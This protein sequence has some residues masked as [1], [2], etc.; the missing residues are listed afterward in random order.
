MN[1]NFLARI[2]FRALTCIVLLSACSQHAKDIELTDLNKHRTYQDSKLDENNVYHPD[3]VSEYQ[4]VLSENPKSPNAN[5]LL[6]RVLDDNQLGLLLKAIKLDSLFAPAYNSL[7]VYYLYK[8]EQP[9]KALKYSNKAISIDSTISYYYEN[10]AQAYIKLSNSTEDL[11]EKYNYSQC[12]YNMYQKANEK[13]PN[14]NYSDD[15]IVLENY[16]LELDE[17]KRETAHIGVWQYSNGFFSYTKN[18]YQNGTWNTNGMF[19]YS[20]GSW[21]R[22]AGKITFYEGGFIYST[23]TINAEGTILS[24]KTDAGTFKLKKRST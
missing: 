24:E 11:N 19:G 20:S 12:S 16:I 21:E 10:A 8:S 4:D 22:N 1:F 18:I 9:R 23:A 15:V 7:S 6:A 2:S 17:L 13:S 14:Q 5:Y 3:L